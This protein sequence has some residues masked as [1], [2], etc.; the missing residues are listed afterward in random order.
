[1]TNKRISL[2]LLIFLLLICGACLPFSTRI[3]GGGTSTPVVTG[4]QATLE[5]AETAYNQGQY[6]AA[7]QYFKK[8]LS[9]EPNPPR[10][11]A[12]LAGYGLAA[13][14]ANLYNE[15]IEIYAR[16]IRDFP[17]GTFSR[18]AKPRLAE[19]YLVTGDA[20][21]A[22][23]M[24]RQLLAEENDP[25][26]LTRLQLVMAQS[27]WLQ[28]NYSEAAGN[29][30]TV[31]RSS[32]GQPKK[33]A[34][35]GVKASLI[36]LDAQT[37]AAIQQQYGQN[38]PGP[39][40]T[41]LL[42]RM[43][44]EVGETNAAQAQADYFS[45][46]FSSH[47][48]MKEVSA[49][50]QG[51]G[52]KAQAFGRNYDPRGAAAAALTGTGGAATMGSLSGLQTTGSVTV[53]MILP[54]SGN[55]SSQ[56]AQK[57]AKGLKLAIDTY[58]GSGR[59]GLTVMDTKGSPEEAARLVGQA[60]ADTKVMAVVGPFLSQESE[61]AAQAANKANL[62]L[63]AISQRTDL[64]K[65][66]PN[67]FRIF[68]TPKHQAEAVARY[69]VRVQ[70]HK[71]LG[72]LYPDDNYGSQMRS[73]FEAEA[74]RLGA[75]VTMIDSYDPQAK[76]WEEAVNRI[77]GGKVARKVSISHQADVGFTALYMPDSAGPVSQIA[78]YLALHD[79]TKMQYLGSPL[80]LN[81]DLL[82]SSASHQIQ[83]AVIPAAIS[84]MSQREESRRF[85]ADYQ[86]AYGQTP[87]QFAAYGYDAGLAIIKA[88]GQGASTREAVRRFLTQAG[89]IPGAT[90]P[91]SFD[92]TGE[93]LVE[94]AFLTIEGREFI[95]LKEPGQGIR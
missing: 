18:E 86:Q 87:D 54:M 14:K 30:L 51:A 39:E 72:I 88:V 81:K 53:A 58:G 21:R 9:E 31:W 29:F 94:P 65:I 15:A 74:R 43:A 5:A 89:T 44:V 77:T 6:Q 66:G 25:A 64:T 76:D 71:A 26:R 12:V 36:N 37:L 34:E 55:S 48:L 33:D 85:I 90:G 67:V 95:L 13:E 59:I 79:V 50:M 23:G 83:G 3:G 16:L 62:P 93:Y 70:G 4:P 28:R 57:I 2:T 46:Y 11:E 68:L 49:L 35:E 7:V 20:A 82:T 69:A 41:Y 17:G 42:V 84:E 8:Y 92:S 22:E 56:Y 27:Q 10:L 78:P 19:L 32:S 63:I 61:L 47:P 75:Q 1:M 80:W 60:A 40:A 73:Y 45:R 91:F 38:F 52:V 24:A